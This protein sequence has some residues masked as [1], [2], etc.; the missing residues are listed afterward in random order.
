MPIN[1]YFY[2]PK[3]RFWIYWYIQFIFDFDIVISSCFTVDG[4]YPRYSASI[5]RSWDDHS[6]ASKGG[7]IRL[8]IGKSKLL[9]SLD[10]IISAEYMEHQVL[11]W[12]ISE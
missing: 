4:P 8:G 1:N 3:I 2:E 9:S 5:I 7:M 6:A 10:I 11:Q 12:T